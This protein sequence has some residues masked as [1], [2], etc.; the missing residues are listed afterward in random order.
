[1]YK[2]CDPVARTVTLTQPVYVNNT[3]DITTHATSPVILNSPRAQ[4]VSSNV[5]KQPATSNLWRLWRLWD[6]RRCAAS[7]VSGIASTAVASA[8]SLAL[9]LRALWPG[10][11]SAQKAFRPMAQERWGCRT[12]LQIDF[13]MKTVSR[14]Y[15][16]IFSGFLLSFAHEKWT[17]D[18][19]GVTGVTYV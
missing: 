12:E 8:A 14:I 7:I 15:Q 18:I 13:W 1:M 2:P 4:R 5:D 11:A 9:L 3:L 10:Q 6:A 17:R 19:C 16:R